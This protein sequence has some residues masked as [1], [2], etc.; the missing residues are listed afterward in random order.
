[1]DM[2]GYARSKGV[3]NYIQAI[4]KVVDREKSSVVK[5]VIPT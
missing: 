1:M 4:I 2:S 5:S 3:Y